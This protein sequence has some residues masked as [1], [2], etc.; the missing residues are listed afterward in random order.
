MSQ[1]VGSERRRVAQ[2]LVFYGTLLLVLAVFVFPFFWM[3]FNSFKTNEKLQE[4]PPVFVFRPTLGNFR[5][6]FT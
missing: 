3:A 5:S 4:Y 2:R 1:V 6:V